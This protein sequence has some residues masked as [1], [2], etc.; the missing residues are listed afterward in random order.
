MLQIPG[1]PPFPESWGL[2]QL[3]SRC[4]VFVW[5]VIGVFIEGVCSG[6]TEDKRFLPGAMMRGLPMKPPWMPR[7]SG[8]HSRHWLCHRAQAHQDLQP[9]VALAAKGAA[10]ARIRRFKLLRYLASLWRGHS[11]PVTSGRKDSSL[12]W[13]SGIKS[14]EGLQK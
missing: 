13:T 12:A 1:R 3:R 7:W 6:S 5:K 11:G 4:P 14:P 10:A 8:V 9:R 2:L